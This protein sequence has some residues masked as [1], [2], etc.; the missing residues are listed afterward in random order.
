MSEFLSI[1]P[2]P[3]RETEKWRVKCT[4]CWLYFRTREQAETF[5]ATYRRLY[6]ES[7]P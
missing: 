2:A 3:W 1:E 7:K 4:D 5:V 6:P